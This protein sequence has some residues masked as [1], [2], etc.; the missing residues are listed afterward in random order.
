MTVTAGDPLAAAREAFKR[1]EWA[2]A[3]DLFGQVAPDALAP[4]DLESMADA[5]WWSAKPD[6]AIEL[7]QRAYA[8]YVAAGKPA[9]A[10]YVALA[11][12]REY[13]VKYASAL[14]RSWFNRAKQL[15]EAEPES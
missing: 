7:L 14:S 5:A 10:G 4:E 2:A 15:L 3:L 12:A 9:R 13:G 8:A 1:D 6:A 11:L